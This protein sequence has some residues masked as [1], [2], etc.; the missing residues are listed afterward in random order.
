MKLTKSIH[1][2]KLEPKVQQSIITII[3]FVIIILLLLSVGFSRFTLQAVPLLSFCLG[4]YLYHRTPGIYI[5]F[6]F[7]M[8]FASPEIQRFIDYKTDSLNNG[9]L[10]FTSNLV[11]SIAILTLV[12]YLPKL[13]VKNSLPFLLTLLASIYSLILS[14]INQPPR[15]FLLFSQFPALVGPI[16]FGFFIY[17]NWENYPLL[18]K[19]IENT[20]LWSTPILSIYSFFQY[21]VAPEWDRHWLYE[22]EK[23]SYGLPEPFSIRPWSGTTDFQTHGITC[24]L[25]FLVLVYRMDWPLRFPSMS[26]NLLSI[27]LT[28]ARA[29]WLSALIATFIFMS[30]LKHKMLARI[31]LSI[32]FLLAAVF[33]MILA[34]QEVYQ[35]ISNRVVGLFLLKDGDYSLNVRTNLYADFFDSATSQIIGKGLAVSVDLGEYLIADAPI[36]IYLF[37]FGWIGLLPYLLGL[38]IM[39]YEL[40]NADVEYSDYLILASK[41]FVLGM[42]AMIGFNNIFMGTIGFYLWCF[43]C[44]GLAGCKYYKHKIPQEV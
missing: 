35:T 41:S 21:V 43:L 15:D 40:C 17:I 38:F 34:N 9:Y 10:S 27:L 32:I 20:F 42:I 14:I 3:I 13:S 5:G 8:H 12:R 39:V 29:A 1:N 18:K 7:W 24:F 23:W 30:N 16:I 44:V 22:V 28:Q 36:F 33:L 11:S 37:Y 26:I 25:G 31:V 6:A 2:R 19:S 4:L